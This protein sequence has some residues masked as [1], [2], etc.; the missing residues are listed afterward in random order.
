MSPNET[1]EAWRR[2]MD[3][4]LLDKAEPGHLL[5]IVSRGFCL[6]HRHHEG[7]DE[8]SKTTSQYSM[9][10]NSK[11]KVSRI[12]TEYIFEWLVNTYYYIY[13]Y[14]TNY[15]YFSFLLC[16]SRIHV[17]STIAACAIALFC[18]KSWCLEPQPHLKIRF[19]VL[20][21]RVKLLQN[22]LT[23]CIVATLD[24]A[25]PGAPHLK[26]LSPKLTLPRVLRARSVD[27]VT[28][29][30]CAVRAVWH[31]TLVRW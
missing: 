13:I 31:V 26:R 4:R 5:P 12:D 27:I 21:E 24:D 15:Q 23:R 1:N 11:C 14:F 22:T 17:V 30:A 28:S 19:P 8:E 20:W 3:M 25:T 6:H 7:W 10:E 9:T 16:T 18:Y 2:N 29:W